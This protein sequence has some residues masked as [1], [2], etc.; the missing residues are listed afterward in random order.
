[1]YPAVLWEI[2]S[3][4]DGLVLLVNTTKGQFVRRMAD[5]IYRHYGVRTQQGRS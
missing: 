5:E 2:V 4:A 3:L 1:V